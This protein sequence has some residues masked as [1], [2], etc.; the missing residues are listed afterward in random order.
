MQLYSQAVEYYSGMNDEKYMF[1]TERIQN[2]LLKP[3]ILKLMKD[4][5]TGD[6]ESKQ[7]YKRQMLEKKQMEKAM[8]HQE[9]MKLRQEEH[10]MRKR[11]RIDQLHA[12]QE[13]QDLI[14]DPEF[15]KEKE[16]IETSKKVVQETVQII[17]ND[18]KS[19]KDSI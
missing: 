1:F 5:N 14:H 7:E 3:E 2:T 11:A 18:I 4:S 16:I 17:Q 12:T 8:T 6:E 19:Q 10:E 13:N 15:I 9:L